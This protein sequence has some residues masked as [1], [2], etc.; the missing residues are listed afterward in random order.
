MSNIF[1]F[2]G[3]TFIGLGIIL[4]TWLKKKNIFTILLVFF[5]SVSLLTI[6]E[7]IVL[8][9]LGAYEYKPGVFR[10]YFADDVV[11][12]FWGNYF[13][14]AGAANL[15]VNFSLGNGWIILISVVFMLI[16]TLFIN[17]GIYKH[18]WWQTYMT[19]I[20]VFFGMNIIKIW[21]SKLNEKL[22]K[23]FLRYITYFF[24]AL[25]LIHVP[26]HLLLLIGKQHYSIGWVENFYR[27]SIL[28]G[29]PYHAGMSLVYVF[30]CCVLQ[31]RLWKLLPILFFVL[32]DFVL[33]NMNI[34]IF[35]DHWNFFYQVVFRA[36]SLVIFIFYT[37][38]CTVRWNRSRNLTESIQP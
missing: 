20:L 19:G 29:L 36:V 5:L 33:I 2:C 25:I 16:E 31:A 3:L 28:F 22:Y 32:S 27:D 10:D 21:V 4:F 9:V 30:F 26:T 14:W 18:H 11:G 34:L 37:S 13:L 7:Y 15:I 38:V 23:K 35:Q 24:F 17:L 12:Y 6:G 1:W 8:T